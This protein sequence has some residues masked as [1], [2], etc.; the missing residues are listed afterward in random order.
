MR[1][2]RVV[3]VNTSPAKG[4]RKTPVVSAR[5]VEDMGIEGDAHAGTKARQISLLASESIERMTSRGMRL[6]PGDFAENVTTEG[7]DLTAL[8]VGTRLAL[9]GGIEVEVTQIG[10]ECH[11]RCAIYDKAGDC[12]M[13]R[14]GIFAKVIKGGVL[15][16]GDEGWIRD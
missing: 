15:K 1:R 13:P 2:F 14:E 5:L 3:S 7:V 9:G 12:V 6:G 4:E 10:K 16:P 8:A 11:G